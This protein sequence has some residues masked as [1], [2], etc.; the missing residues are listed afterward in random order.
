V[1]FTIALLWLVP[2]CFEDVLAG[3][4]V[5]HQHDFGLRLYLQ[6]TA[7][8]GF[9]SLAVILIG[10]ITTWAGYIKNVRW[11]W[12][13]MFVIVWG[14][15]FPVMAF[16]D[17]VYPLYRGALQIP[18]FS[19]LIGAAFSKPGVARTIAHEMVVF[20]LMVIALVLP[21]KSF[22]WGGERQATAHA[23]RE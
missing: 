5:V 18:S 20:I 4:D 16:P 13:V 21:I 9:A 17:F 6:E 11:A 7:A 12:F 3:R 19:D 23:A 1:L 22:F 2:W 15:A 8:L 10:L 14:W